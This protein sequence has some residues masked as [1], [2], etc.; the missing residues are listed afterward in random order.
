MERVM[1]NLLGNAIR[2]TPA[3]GS[4]TVQLGSPSAKEWFW[5]R[6]KD[7][8]EGIAPEYLDKVFDKFEQVRLKREGVT[9]GSSGLGLA[10]CKMVVE[11]HGGRIWAESEGEGKGSTFGF[12]L[13]LSGQKTGSDPCVGLI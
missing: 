12:E 7:T 3:G 2:H 13:P 1:A 5:V 9:V 6:V 11:A 4:V 10:F 8:G